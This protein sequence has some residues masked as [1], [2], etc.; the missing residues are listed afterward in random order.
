MI[1]GCAGCKKQIQE[2][3]SSYNDVGEQ[4]CD[5]CFEKEDLQKNMLKGFHQIASGSFSVGVLSFFFNP[6]FIL[7]IMAITSGL[8]TIRIFFSK[9]KG[10]AV[11]TKGQA[12]Y[13]AL[14]ILGILMGFLPFLQV[15]LALALRTS[16]TRP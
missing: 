1:I 15:L 4:V 14:A 2:N 16:S 11:D 10:Y 8:Q 5:S 12:G 7:S 3:Q 9:E 13:L 6:L